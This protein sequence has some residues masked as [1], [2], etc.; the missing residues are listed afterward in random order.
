VANIL[1]YLP[2]IMKEFR[3]FQ[4]IANAEN[5][6]ISS[7]WGVLENVLNDQFVSDSTENGVK[8][9]ESVLM[10][11]PK[12]TETLDIRKFRIS[13]RLNE[14]LPYTFTSLEQKLANLCGK[15]G[16][17]MTLNSGTYTLKVRVEL[18][19]K[20]KYDEVDALLNRI[21]PVNL[22]IDLSLLS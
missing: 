5:P 9:W 8:R 16:F 4:S 1:D 20:G 13:T 15:D 19:A 2:N 18:S 6:E 14:Q 21:V 17:T 12:N 10:I 3:E 7:L 11:V 22:L